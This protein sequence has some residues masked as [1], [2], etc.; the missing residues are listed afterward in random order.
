MPMYC[1]H[2]MDRSVDFYG[3]V[4]VS[5]LH[6]HHSFNPEDVEEGDYV[7]V[8]TD[9][10]YSGYF[11]NYILPD[12]KNKFFLVSG[13]SSY[14]VGSNHDPSFL[15]IIES[16]K[17]IKWFCTNPPLYDSS[18]IV[19]LPI[20]F[21][22]KERAGGDQALISQFRTNKTSFNNKK[23]KVLLPYHTLNTNPQRAHLFEELSKLDFVEVQK[24]KLS[25]ADY[26]TNLDNYKYVVCLEGS[27]PDVHRNYECLLVNSIPIN[28]ENTIKRLFNYHKL[29]G[30]FLP[31]WNSLDIK[32]LRGQVYDFENVDKFLKIKYH[33]NLLRGEI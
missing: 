30:V 5:R 10:I 21:E 2:V 18:K 33:H 26:M 17:V 3:S 16:S 23:D 20:G 14:H 9:Y 27:G 29:P 19:P 28:I 22:E 8:K 11:Q 12:I 6:N 32:S 13:I 15:K 7:F 31:D 1:D 25:W 24:D 4:G